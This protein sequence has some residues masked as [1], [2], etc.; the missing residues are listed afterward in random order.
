M[1]HISPRRQADT[2]LTIVCCCKAVCDRHGTAERE[3]VVAQYESLYQR[4]V[5][6]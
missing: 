4:T 3:A 5:D 2:A 6:A 1:H